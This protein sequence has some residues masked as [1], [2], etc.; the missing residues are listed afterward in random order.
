MK[1]YQAEEARK[2]LDTLLKRNSDP[3]E[4]VRDTVLEII[5]TVRDRGDQALLDYTQTFDG[6]RLS[7]LRVT[8]EEIEEAKASIDPALLRAFETAAEHIKSFH[9]HQKEESFTYEARGGVILGQKITPIEKAGIYVP[10][11]KAAYPST[12]LM[13]ALPAKVAGVKKIVM[14]TPPGKDG[15]IPANILACADIAG[16]DEIYKVGGAQAIAALAYGTESVP[17]VDKITGPGNIFV[18]TAKKEV[19]GRVAIDMI[20][21]PSEVLVIA[22]ESANPA[23]VAADLLAQ[24]EHDE[25]AMPVLVTTDP[26]LPGKVAAEIDRQIDEDLSRKSIARASVNDYGKI[27]VAETL[28]EAFD[29]ANRIAPEHLE[30]SI[31]DAEEH[32]DDVKNAGAIFIGSYTPEPVGDYFA[33][34][35]HTLPTS[36]TA[37]FSSPLGVYDFQKR[38]SILKYD[39]DALSKEA[40]DVAAFARSEGLDAH[41]RSVERRF[42]K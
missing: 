10:G 25:M 39:R 13:N 9:E 36:G 42:E 30:L 37:R 6:V 24:A 33:G 19:F 17:A 23:W 40:R 7:S 4:S 18:A 32:V 41:A 5:D 27:F 22:D 3:G 1:I 21:G 8:P 12:V 15:K 28:G 29:L 34:P 16:V 31:R 14:T 38:S 35:N 26:T 2:N 20:A 11:G